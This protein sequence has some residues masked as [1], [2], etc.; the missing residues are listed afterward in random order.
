MDKT[1]I[2][3]GFLQQYK[4]LFTGWEIVRILRHSQVY[5]FGRLNI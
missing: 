4:S 5:T 2:L 3:E 1:G